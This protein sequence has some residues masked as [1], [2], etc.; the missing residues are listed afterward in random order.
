MVDA[1]EVK[2]V[3]CL[4]YGEI[5]AE[6]G[7][8]ALAEAMPAAPLRHAY[9]RQAA[10]E[11]KHARM[12]REHLHAI[13]AEPVEVPHLPEL[14]AYRRLLLG[15][16]ERGRLVS[17]V[18][19]VNVALEGIAAVGLAL[20]ARWVE[21][22]GEDP[23]WV[24]LMGAVERDE[25]R[26]TRLARP[27]LLALGGG[28]IPREAAEAMGEVREAAVATLSGLGSD[29]AAWG[30]DPVRLFDA[31]IRESHPALAGALL[32]AGAAA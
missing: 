7:A 16:A 27:A 31:A 25:R 32:D 21:A 24:A 29:L 3:H 17:L 6:M 30:V 10:D 15:A 4:L 18:L 1:R 23:A 13:G 22:T 19:G 9:R 12:F 5:L 26:H 14:D 8:K 2:H 28:A 20:S 11:V